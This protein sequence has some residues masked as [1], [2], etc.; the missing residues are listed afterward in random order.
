MTV[1]SQYCSNISVHVVIFCHVYAI[2]A[3]ECAVECVK[4]RLMCV[5]LHHYCCVAHLSSSSSHRYVNGCTYVRRYSRRSGMSFF[6][7]FVSDNLHIIKSRFFSRY[8]NE[9]FNKRMWKRLFFS[10]SA[11]YLCRVMNL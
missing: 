4:V 7:R 1:F 11:Q 5:L 10:R 9:S 8:R 6:W 3:H 2:S